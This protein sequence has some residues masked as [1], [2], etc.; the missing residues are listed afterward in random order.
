MEPQPPS[1][2]SP[3]SSALKTIAKYKQRS[4][5]T[6]LNSHIPLLESAKNPSSPDVVLIGDSMIERMLTTANCGPNLVSPWP[7]QT[8]LP[9]DNSKQFQAGRVL[10]LGV[11]GDKIQ[12][13]AYRLVGDPT[14]RLKSVADMLAARRSVKLWVL[15]VG[16]NNLSP[17]KGLG[18]GDVDALRALVEALLDIGAKGCKVLV[19]GLFLRKDIPW[20][21]IQQANEKIHQVVENFASGHPASVLWLPATEEVK[22]EHLVDHVHLSEAGYKIWIGRSLADETM[23]V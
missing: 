20:E 16:T 14:H 8:M 21:K 5:D 22:E 11:G 10:N 1:P 18:D 12:N 17:K 15:Q 7:S 4:F 9:K 23:R 6:S 19:T 13:V 3:A 2:P